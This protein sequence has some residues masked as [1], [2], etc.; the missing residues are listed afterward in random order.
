VQRASKTSCVGLDGVAPLIAAGK[1]RIN[2]DQTYPLAAIAKA[3]EH[4]RSGRTR[5]KVVVDMAVAV[6]SSRTSP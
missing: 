3:Q 2:I 1:V 5:G 4:N 6:E